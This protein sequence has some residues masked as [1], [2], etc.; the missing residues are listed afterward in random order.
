MRILWQHNF[1]FLIYSQ[2][3]ID[4][5]LVGAQSISFMLRDFRAINFLKN[6][7][8][9]SGMILVFIQ[10]LFNRRLLTKSIMIVLAFGEIKLPWFNFKTTWF[11]NCPCNQVLS[12]IYMPIMFNSVV[13]LQKTEQTNFRYSIVCQGDCQG[14]Y[15]FSCSN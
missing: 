1:F 3:K 4:A 12:N 10:Y 15:L 14:T 11:L 6:N 2:V 13:I 8:F 5:I 7:P 9:F